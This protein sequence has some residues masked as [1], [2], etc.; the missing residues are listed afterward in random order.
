[1]R[2]PKGGFTPLEISDGVTR[3]RI[4]LTGFTLIEMLIAVAIFSVVALALYAAFSSGVSVWRRSEEGMGVYHDVRI[5]LDD[6]AKELKC[7]VFFDESVNDDDDRI[8]PFKGG[9]SEISFPTLLPV[10]AEDG[11]VMPEIVKVFYRFNKEESSIERC[12]VTAAEGYN[13]DIAVK[14]VLRKGVFAFN[15]S[16]PYDTG[17]DDDPYEW[18]DEWDDEEFRV[19]RGV[20]ITLAV[21]RPGGDDSGEE[22]LKAVFIPTGVL[23][24]RELGL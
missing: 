9:A 16:Y 18:K 17:D 1:M 20:M 10:S 13:V 15:L 24:E 8:L 12:A 11:S 3:K 23:G 7:A 21:Q 14:E 4:S 6:M 2:N 19:P 22:F 5:L